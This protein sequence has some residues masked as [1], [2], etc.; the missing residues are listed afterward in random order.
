MVIF[1]HLGGVGKDCE[2]S[3]GHRVKLLSQKGKGTKG[4]QNQELSEEVSQEGHL[5]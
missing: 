4:K 3:L 1:Q 5:R 2:P